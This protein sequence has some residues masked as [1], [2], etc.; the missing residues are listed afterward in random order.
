M[1]Q[2]QKETGR[3]LYTLKEVSDIDCSTWR[4][5]VWMARLFESR[6]EWT[7]AAMSYAQAVR[8]RLFTGRGHSSTVSIA[9]ALVSVA[10][11]GQLSDMRICTFS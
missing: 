10:L 2:L 5:F 8:T 6:S 7:N 11:E 9:C 3:A 1:H 4:P